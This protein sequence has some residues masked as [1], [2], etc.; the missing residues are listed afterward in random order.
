MLECATPEQRVAHAYQPDTDL[1]QSDHRSLAAGDQ[2]CLANRTPCQQH[3][4]CQA[5]S[6]HQSNPGSLAAGGPSCLKKQTGTL[7]KSTSCQAAWYAIAHVHLFYVHNTPSALCISLH[8]AYYVRYMQVPSQSLQHLLQAAY[9]VVL[10]VLQNSVVR[11]NQM[12]STATA[13]T[14]LTAESSLAR[15]NITQQSN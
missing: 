15:A 13:C 3:S 2:S 4:L 8:K 1:D 9:T 5:A 12:R 7:D 11:H 6:A 14:A 10:C